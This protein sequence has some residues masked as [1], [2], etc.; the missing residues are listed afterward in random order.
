[1]APA[2]QETNFFWVASGRWCV[3]VYTGSRDQVYNSPAGALTYI[4]DPPAVPAP[5]WAGGGGALYSVP[6]RTTWRVLRGSGSLVG[7]CL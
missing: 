3:G 2:G 4:L 6:G 1:M 5:G 7:E